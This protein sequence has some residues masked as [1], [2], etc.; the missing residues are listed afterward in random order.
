MRLVVVARCVLEDVL[1][2]L[3]VNLSDKGLKQVDRD[4]CLATTQRRLGGVELG[5]QAAG[6]S[7]IV[8]VAK[9]RSVLHTFP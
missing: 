8:N 5:E 3:R 4:F 2:R 1:A 7:L 9:Q 6:N